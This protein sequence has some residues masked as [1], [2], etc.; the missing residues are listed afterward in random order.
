[1]SES[2]IRVLFE[3]DEP[4]ASTVPK[5]VL[6]QL[7]DVPVDMAHFTAEGL[8]AV[9]QN[10][11]DVTVSNYQIPE[12]GGVEQV[13]HPQCRP[14]VDSFEVGMPQDTSGHGD[15]NRSLKEK[16]EL[17][18]L[19]F[20]TLAEG[21]VVRDSEG[22]LILCNDEAANIF[23]LPSADQLMIRGISASDTM[24]EDGTPC[25]HEDMPT[26]ITFR[27][28]KPLT[29]ILRGIKIGDGPV[30]W[31]LVNTRPNLV[32]EKITAVVVSIND[33]T[34]KLHAEKE[35]QDSE[36]R[37]RLIAENMSDV[38]A[39]I[40]MDLQHVYVSPSCVKLRGFTAEE[41][42]VQSLKD[43]FVPDSLRTALGVFREE[44]EADGK[45]GVDLDRVRYMELE[46]YCKDGSTK[47]IGNS[48]RPIRGADGKPIS[49]I[50]L[51]RDVTELRASIQALH[52]ANGKLAMLS[53][54]TRHD[55][56]NQ[57]QVVGGWLELM[58]L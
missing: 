9:V 53:R 8:Q 17:H 36:R 25:S 29:N 49:I 42:M 33:V 43:I 45:E 48:I 2:P 57:L 46:E 41:V 28:G 52:E 4:K 15:V 50:I 24:L 44:M 58:H 55:I 40:D 18:R 10:R 20:E 5:D 38:I 22:K 1:M 27:T 3:G 16:A 30:K 37:F 6:E 56:M 14:S 35:L 11:Y 12:T 23:G 51:S 54:L 34:S 31:V 26:T 19:V 21:L 32:G 13:R 39:V 47:W 7:L